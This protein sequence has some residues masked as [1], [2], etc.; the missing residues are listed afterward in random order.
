VIDLA[1]E[2]LQAAEV[3]AGGEA[4]PGVPARLLQRLADRLRDVPRLK[5]RGDAELGLLLLAVG[6]D[7]AELAAIAVPPEMARARLEDVEAL[8]PGGHDVL[9][10]D[11]RRRLVVVGG[12]RPQLDALEALA[13]VERPEAP[14]EEV[15]HVRRDRAVCPVRQDRRPVP[16]D[17]RLEERVRRVARAEDVRAAHLVR[18]GVDRR[19]GAIRV[20]NPAAL[21]VDLDRDQPGDVGVPREHLLQRGFSIDPGRRHRHEASACFRVFES[22]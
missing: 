19:H 12:L 1:V 14:V 3:R 13:A 9:H 18:L 20:V 5:P 16:Q 8:R 2:K 10:R 4:D 11:A 17:Q 21:D 22:S 15:H 6:V 7:V